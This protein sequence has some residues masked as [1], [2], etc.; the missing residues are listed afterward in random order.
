MLE[1]V[2]QT[3]G[4]NGRKLRVGGEG[5]FAGG[6]HHSVREERGR[7][8]Y[9]VNDPFTGRGRRSVI[10]APIDELRNKPLSKAPIRDEWLYD[11]DERIERLHLRYADQAI[12]LLRT[13]RRERLLCARANGEVVAFLDLSSA[14]SDFYRQGRY[15]LARGNFGLDCFELD[16]PA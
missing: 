12:V 6:R 1:A 16:I 7:L 14:S 2:R 15:L 8:V 5:L 9:E 11:S 4:S 13:K 10:E 3:D